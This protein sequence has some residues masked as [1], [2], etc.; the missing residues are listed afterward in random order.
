VCRTSPIAATT[1][2]R[3]NT[4]PASAS[5]GIW[6]NPLVLHLA[7]HD[8]NGIDMTRDNEERLKLYARR[9]IIVKRI[10]LNMDQVR[11]HNPPANFVK[12]DDKRTAA[13]R[14]QFGTDECWELD[15]LAPTVIT[16]LIRNAIN[17]LIDQDRWRKAMAHEQR[18]RK[19]VA[20]IAANWTGTL[21]RQA[22]RPPCCP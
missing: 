1:R 18:G 3:C 8:P 10:A 12:E 7:D 5:P 16:D 19:L 15:A 14:E 13:Y 6:T 17:G 22:E 20:D 21:S 11:L 2:R 9:R 4:K